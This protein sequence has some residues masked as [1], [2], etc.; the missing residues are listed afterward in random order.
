QN[1]SYPTFIEDEA[2]GMGQR[3]Y[4]KENVAIVTDTVLGYMPFN[5]LTTPR[6]RFRVLVKARVHDFDAAHPEYFGYGVGWSYG[7]REYIP[8]RVNGELY[9]C[10]AEDTPE[11][12]DLGLLNLPP[13]ADSEVVN[14]PSFELRIYFIALGAFAS[15]SAFDIISVLLLP[16]DEGLVIVDDV[17]AADVLAIDGISDRPNVYFSVGGEVVEYPNKMGYP[18]TLGREITRIYVCRDDGRDVTFSSEVHYQPQ[19][20]LS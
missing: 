13:I 11:V 10:A 9:Y 19:F 4:I 6:G 7:D 17:P 1:G 3:V 12:L 15:H 16:A 5:F 20:L 2:N 18:F 8:T 14:M